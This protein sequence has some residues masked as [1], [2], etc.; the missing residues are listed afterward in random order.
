MVSLFG[1]VWLWSLLSFVAGVL[2][3][4]LV[5]VRPAKSR[6]GE[7][8]DQLADAR[9]RSRPAPVASSA[10]AEP[11]PDG[12]FDE[13]HVES[14]SL[15]DE[16]LTPE[17]TGPP[18]QPYPAPRHPAPEYPATPAHP[19]TA[20]PATS[21]TAPEP[22]VVTE[23]VFE[24][25]V[26]EPERPVEVERPVEPAYEPEPEPEPDYDEL[27]P[28]LTRI[29]QPAPRPAHDH[30]E[31]EPPRS[32]FERLS[33]ETGLPGLPVPAAEA[34]GMFNR[35]GLV[36]GAAEDV[37]ADLPVE[38]TQYLSPVAQPP[39]VEIAPVQEE[40]TAPPEVEDFHPVEVWREQ[41]EPELEFLPRV[42]QVHE[43]ELLEEDEPVALT[44]RD[45]ISALEQT[46]FISA[47]EVE[48]ILAEEDA[49]EA[50]AAAVGA[51]EVEVAE[52]IVVEEP[53]QQWPDRDLTGEYPIITEEIA[54]SHGQLAEVH[55]AEEAVEEVVPEAVEVPELVEV[56]VE[57][58]E[59]EAVAEEVAEEV[60]VEPVAEEPPAPVAPPAPPPPPP[61]PVVERPRSLFEPI[62]DADADAETPAEQP[63]A[64]QPLSDQPFVPVLAP[65]LLEA[66]KSG[67]GLPQR[68]QRAPG[69]SRQSPS[70][71]S[72]KPASPPPPPPPEPPRPVR[73]RPVGFSPS[74]GGR[75]P[76]NGTTRY[77]QPEGF[78][79]RSPFGPGSVLP[80][81]DGLAPAPDFEVKAT[82]TGRRYYT[83]ESAN[84]R[85]TRAD[86]WF[87]T[88]A[89][90]QKAGF[91]QAP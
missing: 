69:S 88:V 71:L 70:P 3:T 67:N 55:E 36:G 18:A 44:P 28:A 81:S 59:E 17:Y 85:E 87:R 74:T 22:T 57:P 9:R 53:A 49:A 52:E 51:A 23:P 62:V 58:V 47:A 66:E 61:A 78:N 8:E 16:V 35:S 15:V 56:V 90:A 82:L 84:F 29:D 5:L 1:Q 63:R 86:V 26:Y 42:D 12:E 25:P 41:D 21:Y 64:M 54:S 13:W 11:L 33:P 10:G 76:P 4:W 91:R 19:A 45:D 6:A 80:K 20:Y 27:P 40:P 14:R 37:E 7:L 73:P 83:D 75:T 46:S 34:T 38:E 24:P 65:E 50:R 68:P 43:D 31:E 89:D 2:L 60:V 30:H 32:L 72:A 79:P 48:R 77:Q 39:V